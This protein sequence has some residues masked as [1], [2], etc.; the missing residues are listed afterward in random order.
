M[1]SFLVQTLRSGNGTYVLVHKSVLQAVLSLLMTEV[2]LGLYFQV[3][4]PVQQ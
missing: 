2:H 4:Y 3:H 1:Q